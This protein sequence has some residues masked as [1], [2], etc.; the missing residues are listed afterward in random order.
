[1][2][3]PEYVGIKFCCQNISLKK[4]LGSTWIEPSSL[5]K[6]SE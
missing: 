2:S 6:A 4:V 3:C 1:M 5:R